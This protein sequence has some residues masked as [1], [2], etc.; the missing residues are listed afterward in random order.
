MNFWKHQLRSMPNTHLLLQVSGDPKRPSDGKAKNLH[1]V[2]VEEGTP[3]NLW[4]TM[5]M[6]V[7]MGSLLF[8]VSSFCAS[9]GVAACQQS[10]AESQHDSCCAPCQYSCACVF[11]TC[12]LQNDRDCGLQIR[13]GGW[14]ALLCSLMGFANSKTSELELK[15]II[16][17]CL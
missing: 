15:T 4:F 14:L 16:S 10:V 3:Q 12:T 11:L 2:P 7:A 6:L 9:A 5:S 13:V 17:T 1:K 8:K